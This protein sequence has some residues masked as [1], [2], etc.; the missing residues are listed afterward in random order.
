MATVNQEQ[1]IIL[2]ACA[3]ILGCLRYRRDMLLT[4]ARRSMLV[5]ATVLA[6]VVGGGLGARAYHNSGPHL[7]SL[8]AS[9][10]SPYVASAA[11][12]TPYVL[13]GIDLCLDEP[14]EVEITDVRFLN[15]RGRVEVL[16]WGVRPVFARIGAYPSL[17]RRLTDLPEYDRRTPVAAPCRTT[18][19]NPE[20]AIEVSKARRQ[21]T[22]AD[23]L[24]IEYRTGW[25]ERELILDFSVTLCGPTATQDAVALQCRAIESERAR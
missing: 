12:D 14:G 1:L 11:A 6:A 5:T 9:G 13:D 2:N 25:H 16:A 8:G 15:M 21:M 22:Y 3:N 7:L 19:D 4:G 24:V 18:V 23:E 20:M 17:S 10:A